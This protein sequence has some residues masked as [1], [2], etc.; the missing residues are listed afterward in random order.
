MPCL[1]I[2]EEFEPMTEEQT[3]NLIYMAGLLDNIEDRAILIQIMTQRF[4]PIPDEYGDVVREIL[5]D[6]DK[7]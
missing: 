7:E 4:G 3:R 1:A 6:Q 2:K 5:A